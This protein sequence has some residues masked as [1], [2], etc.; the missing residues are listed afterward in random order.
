MIAH[1]RLQNLIHQVGNASD[2]GDDI[3]SLRVRNVNLHLQIDGEVKTFA[4]LGLDLLQLRVKIVS[5]RN[6]I[7]PVERN[8]KVGTMTAW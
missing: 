3:R 1:R 7:G 5:L 8:D 2:H 6:D 4:A